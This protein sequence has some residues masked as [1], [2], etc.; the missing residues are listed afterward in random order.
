[1]MLGAPAGPLSL[2]SSRLGL[3]GS[4]LGAGPSGRLG[5]GLPRPLGAGLPG[6]LYPRPRSASFPRLYRGGRLPYL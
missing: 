3:H 4:R 1:M 6:P 2:Y 5:A